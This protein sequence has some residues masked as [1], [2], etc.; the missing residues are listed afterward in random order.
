MATAKIHKIP[1]PQNQHSLSIGEAD[2][3]DDFQLA[4]SGFMDLLDGDEERILIPDNIWYLL[5]PHWR[6][7]NKA[8]SSARKRWGE[9]PKAANDSSQR[10]PKEDAALY[11]RELADQLEQKR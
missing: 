6:K 10:E 7:F 5:D 8:I 4:M 11:F 1:D 9:Q 3:I 2:D